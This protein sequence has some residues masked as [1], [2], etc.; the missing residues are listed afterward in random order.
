MCSIQRTCG[1]STT[2]WRCL[3][4]KS[5][6]CCGVITRMPSSELETGFCRRALTSHVR[7]VV[8]G[9][10]VEAASA[11]HA[12][13]SL[14]DVLAQEAPRLLGEPGTDAGVVVLDREDDVEPDAVHEPKRRDPGCGEDPPRGSLSMIASSVRPQ[15][16]S[17]TQFSSGGW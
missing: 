17:S 11:L 13:A 12:E 10:V 14:L 16:I 9:W 7:C 5:A 8:D 3:S 15:D 1:R 2:S 6:S 4:A